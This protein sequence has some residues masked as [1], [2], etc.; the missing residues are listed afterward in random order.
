LEENNENYIKNVKAGSEITFFEYDLPETFGISLTVAKKLNTV[1]FQ[2][3]VDGNILLPKL[4]QRMLNV[5]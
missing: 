4:D 3:C 2:L 5:L 1:R